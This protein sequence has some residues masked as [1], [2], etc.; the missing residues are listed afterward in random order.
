MELAETVAPSVTAKETHNRR[1][2]GEEVMGYRY[3]VNNHGASFG[4]LVL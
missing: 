4:D 2:P 3:Q 1:E